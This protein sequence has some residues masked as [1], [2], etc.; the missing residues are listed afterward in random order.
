MSG[1]VTL[2]RI[3]NYVSLDCIGGMYAS[4]RWHTKGYLVVYCS[5][6]PSTALL[7]ILVDLEIDGE[8]R[9]QSFQA[10][11]IEATQ[12]VTIERADTKKLGANWPT[13]LIKTRM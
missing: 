2:W 4:G 8:D 3:S 6:D 7:E 5:E 10:V 12:S 1:G 13:D 9:P 11:K